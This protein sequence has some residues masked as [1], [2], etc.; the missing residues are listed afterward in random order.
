MSCLA[1]ESSQQFEAL[2]CDST[3]RVSVILGSR[4]YRSWGLQHEDRSDTMKSGQT[5]CLSHGGQH[6]HACVQLMFAAPRQALD[7]ADL[8]LGLSNV[9]NPQT[10]PQSVK[11][12]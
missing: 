1:G 9:V 11:N 12:K 10:R 8:A 7:H 4:A 2:T 6:S 3:E 5:S